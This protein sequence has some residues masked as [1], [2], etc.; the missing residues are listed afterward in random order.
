MTEMPLAVHEA[1]L[2]VPDDT[3][4]SMTVVIGENKSCT[5]PHVEKGHATDTTATE[6][7][8]A[9]VTVIETE[10]DIV[11]QTVIIDPDETITGKG[12]AH[13]REIVHRQVTAL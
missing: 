6:S 7:V 10:D 4:P 12:H 5:E 3:I 1:A 11:L 13:G 8:I 9:T 2:E